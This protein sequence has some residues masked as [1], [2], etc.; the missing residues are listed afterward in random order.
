MIRRFS[1]ADTP[2]ASDSG[3]ALDWRQVIG[4]KV[5]L[6]IQYRPQ[7]SNFVI[8]K[9]SLVY[10][11]TDADTNF[12]YGWLVASDIPLSVSSGNFTEYVLLHSDGRFM[13]ERGLFQNIQGLGVAD[14][15]PWYTVR[16]AD[17]DWA[18][19]GKVFKDSRG[20][21]I[22]TGYIACDDPYWAEFEG[23]VR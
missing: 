10:G 8:C 3:S 4:F 7:H 6:A 14:G 21:G 15:I 9:G 23:V 11:F 18:L 22:V 12:P 19:V 16:K 13:L 1:F 20:D 17:G 5:R 2:S